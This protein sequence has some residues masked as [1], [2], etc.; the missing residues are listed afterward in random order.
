MSIYLTAMN[1]RAFWYPWGSWNQS[2]MVHWEISCLSLLIFCVSFLHLCSWKRLVL[3]FCNILW[4]FWNRDST[5]FTKGVLKW[6][7]VF[8]GRV[9]V[10]D[11]CICSFNVWKFRLVKPFK[12]SLLLVVMF[13]FFVCLNWNSFYCGYN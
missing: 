4:R 7:F 5:C 11:D 9:C 10:K 12:T 2:L 1:I 8:F 6:Y 13:V 3:L